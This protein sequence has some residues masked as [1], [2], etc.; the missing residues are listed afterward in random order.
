MEISKYLQHANLPISDIQDAKK[1]FL[2]KDITN[3]FGYF[4]RIANIDHEELLH[5]YRESVISFHL[6]R[7]TTPLI[8]YVVLNM[9]YGDGTFGKRLVPT[10]IVADRKKTS[11]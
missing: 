2:Q 11:V 6:V 10:N 5:F 1:I 3:D 9:V 7:R 4:S 8:I